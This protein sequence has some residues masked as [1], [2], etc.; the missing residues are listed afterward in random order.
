M[1]EFTIYYGTLPDGRNKIGVDCAYPRRIMA[2]KLTN[3]RVLE[4]HTCV[5]EVSDREQALQHQHGVKVDKTP[6]HVTYF[7]NKNTEKRAKTSAALIGKEGWAK[8]IPKSQEHKAKMSAAQ[9]GVSKS[10]VSVLKMKLA[11][12]TTTPEL[13][14]LVV[15]DRILGMP[16]HKLATKYNIG[17]KV[18]RR[19]IRDINE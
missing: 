8:G 9:K 4:V 13:D 6:Y 16:L 12:R 5:Y 10:K 7:F 14:L 3:H 18:V 1:E 19:I 11:L 17:I 15:Q 2:Q